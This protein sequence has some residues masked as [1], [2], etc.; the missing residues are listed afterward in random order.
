MACRQGGRW[1]PVCLASGLAEQPKHEKWVENEEED[2]AMAT[3]PTDPRPQAPGDPSP[4]LP[5]D[6]PQK[7]PGI[8]DPV[9]IPV[10]PPQRNPVDP[11]EP[12]S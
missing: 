6:P 3:T 9:P 10:D 2:V 12:M 1:H 5:I 7:L 11:R 8:P 4:Q